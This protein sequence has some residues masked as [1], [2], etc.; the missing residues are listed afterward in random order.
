MQSQTRDVKSSTY[1][2]LHHI[3]L[4]THKITRHRLDNAVPHAQQ[5]V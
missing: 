2:S 5:V 1:I 3:A 4:T